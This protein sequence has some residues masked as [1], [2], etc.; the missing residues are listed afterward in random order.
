MHLKCQTE[1]DIY[2]F[3]H[4]LDTGWKFRI[5]VDEYASVLHVS[6]FNESYCVK[7][8]LNFCH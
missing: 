5:Q 1:S 7:R 6:D 2:M 8:I 4:R 3:S